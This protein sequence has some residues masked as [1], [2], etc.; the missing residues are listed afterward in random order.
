MSPREFGGLALWAG[1]L[2]MLC[3][4]F[5]TEQWHVYLLN[6]VRAP[7]YRHEE[8]DFIAMQALLGPQALA[9]P[10]TSAIKSRL[11]GESEPHGFQLTLFSLRSKARAATRQALR[12]I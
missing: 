5:V 8:L 11:V 4:A 7:R 10:A 1:S 6:A 2:Y 9:F 3:F 12:P